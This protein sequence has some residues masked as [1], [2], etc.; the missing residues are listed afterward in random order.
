MIVYQ[1]SSAP[2]TLSDLKQKIAF[3]TKHLYPE[4]ETFD[5]ESGR[6]SARMIVKTSRLLIGI[7]LF[8]NSVGTDAFERILKFA[9]D[10]ETKRAAHTASDLE[11][12]KHCI[13]APEFSGPFIKRVWEDFPFVELFEWSALRSES[14]EALLLRGVKGLVLND[15]TKQANGNAEAPS[16]E[17]QTSMPKSSLSSKEL[18]A[19]THFGL[20]LKERRSKLK[21]QTAR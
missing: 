3:V 5:A 13:V 17:V 16:V 12:F 9:L 7:E 11:K 2:Q 14:G 8:G 18:I 21:E 15:R 19:L 20:E 6:D 4:G 1:T 10:L